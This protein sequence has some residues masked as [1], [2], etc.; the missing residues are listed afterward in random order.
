MGSTLKDIASLREDYSLAS[1]LERDAH[2]NPIE[3]FKI[4]FHEA[5]M[6]EIEDVNAMTLSTLD[7]NAKPHARIVLLKGIEEN[8]VVFFTNYQS[9][10]G[11]EISQNPHVSIVFHWKE[12]Q[13]QVRI[14]GIAAKISDVESTNYFQSRPKES[15]IGAWASAQ[16]EVL[17]SREELEARFAKLQETYNDIEV[18]KP[19]HW[20]GYAVKPTLIEFW[21]GRSSR[22]HDR[23]CYT[24]VQDA[25]W[26]MKRLNP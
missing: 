14:E 16:S 1:L 21:Q 4:W 26:E 25:H 6:A 19:P 15:Q 3:Q 9:H 23:L 17:S 8:Q 7:E 2:S 10:K 24:L 5:V 20:G 18:P 12:L 11:I 22:L 13:R